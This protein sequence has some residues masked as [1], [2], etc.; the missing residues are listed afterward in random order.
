MA[1]PRLTRERAAVLLALLGVT[2]VAWAYLV[3][4]QR[5][6]AA[7]DMGGMAGMA[8]PPPSGVAAFALIFAMWWIMMLGMML[9]SAAPMILTFATIAHRQR[10]RGQAFVPATV[11]TAG[12][13][14]AWGAFSLAAS[15]LQWGLDASGLLTPMMQAR[16]AAIGGGL[17]VLAGLYQFSPWK[18]ACLRHCRTPLGFLLGHWREGW[19]GALR[20]GWAHGIY[21]AGCCWVLMLLLFAVGVMNLAWVAVIAGL[22]FV[23]KLLPAG[24]WLGRAAGAGMVAFGGYL[25]VGGVG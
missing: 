18:Y 23:E 16:G 11:F 8:M 7:M 3:V 20:M 22:V 12:Y 15:L 6:M 5:Q 14:L 10:A 21:C 4:A 24:V 17:F 25:L 19:G 9:P 2:A 13:L 1:A